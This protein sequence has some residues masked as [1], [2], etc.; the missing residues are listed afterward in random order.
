M[1]TKVL[2]LSCDWSIKIGCNYTISFSCLKIFVL[3]LDSGPQRKRKG[4]GITKLDDIFGRSPTMP[5]IKIM[6]N[7]YG[8]PIG[9]NARKFSSAIGCQVRRTISVACP[10]WRLVDAE[11]KFEVWTNIKVIA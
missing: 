1:I 7:E 6:V 3:D 2:Y 4:R 8:Q 10:D 9:Q 11:K 5:K